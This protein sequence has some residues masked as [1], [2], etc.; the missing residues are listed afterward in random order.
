MRLIVYLKDGQAV[1]V[2]CKCFEW[3]KCLGFL[4]CVDDEDRPVAVFPPEAWVG[5]RKVS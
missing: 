1:T 5:C 4:V 2:D 3:T